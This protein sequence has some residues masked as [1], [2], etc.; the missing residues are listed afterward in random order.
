M[1]RPSILTNGVK[2]LRTK[3]IHQNLGLQI[4]NLD[5]LIRSGAQPVAI[6]G[7][8]EGMDDF[9]CIEGVESLAFVQIPQHRRPILSSRGTEGS[10]GGD[11]DGVEVSGVTNEIVA[12]LAIGQTP[13]FD[14]TIPSA[15]HNEGHLHA[16]RETDAGDPFIVSIRVGSR[17]INGIL[18]FSE[19][20][21]QL[22]RFV[23]RPGDYLTIDDRKGHREDILCM[24]DE[25]SCGFAGV[26][27]PEKLA[28]KHGGVYIAWG[29]MVEP[30]VIPYTLYPN[31]DKE[32]T[33]PL[34]CHRHCTL[35][36]IERKELILIASQFCIVNSEKN[37]SRLKI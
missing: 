29:V 4:P 36:Y 31:Y 11:T 33:T 10:I 35:H 12:E 24:A 1:R 20:I 9:S 14:E 3:G 37:D 23:P 30:S 32:T 15:G 7:E 5:L 2:M 34:Q 25:S 21:P 28:V 16:G 22:N 19:G 13:D 8:A 18:A 17:R 26:D 6:G 27:F